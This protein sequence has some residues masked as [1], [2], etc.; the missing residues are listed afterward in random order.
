MEALKKILYAIGLIILSPILLPV[1]FIVVIGCSIFEAIDFSVN[2]ISPIFKKKPP[3]VVGCPVERNS[4]QSFLPLFSPLILSFS[5]IFL[6]PDK[7]YL[8]IQN[9]KNLEFNSYFN[10]EIINNTLSELK[11]DNSSAIHIEFDAYPD[12][13]EAINLDYSIKKIIQTNDTLCRVIIQN[14]NISKFSKAHI[15]IGFQKNNVITSNIISNKIRIGKSTFLRGTQVS[16]IL[17]YIQFFLLTGYSFYY[18]IYLISRL[19]KVRTWIKSLAE[20]DQKRYKKN[21]FKGEISLL[22]SYFKHEINRLP[23]RIL[24]YSVTNITISVLFVLFMLLISLLELITI[25]Y[26]STNLINISIIMTVSIICLLIMI[27]RNVLIIHSYNSWLQYHQ[28][29][30]LS[31]GDKLEQEKSILEQNKFHRYLSNGEL[32]EAI[33]IDP[34][35]FPRVE[36]YSMSH[37]KMNFH[38]SVLFIMVLI[39]VIKLIGLVIIF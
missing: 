12:T 17:I 3:D 9:N 10:I 24:E 23:P 28:S 15:N 5:T 27:V 32:Y 38:K 36:L 34:V 19:V 37:F 26:Q 1:A 16:K 20:T 22:N 30:F 4:L 39:L 14:L 2:L 25:F 8:D 35:N 31:F 13:I 21:I 18:F 11:L 7:Q 29:R 6:F 33:K